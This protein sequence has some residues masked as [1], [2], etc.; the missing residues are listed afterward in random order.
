MEKRAIIY[1]RTK[2]IRKNYFNDGKGTYFP[3][4]IKWLQSY[5]RHC[6]TVLTT[7]VKPG[8]KQEESGMEGKTEKWRGGNEERFFV[9]YDYTLIALYSRRKIPFQQVDYGLLMLLL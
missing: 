9:G 4:T 1:Q 2:C 8:T 3:Y 5:R 7:K 6:S